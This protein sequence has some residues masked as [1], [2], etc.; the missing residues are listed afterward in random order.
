MPLGFLLWDGLDVDTVLSDVIQNLFKAARFL[1][2]RMRT[3]KI[4][5]SRAIEIQLAVETEPSVEMAAGSVIVGT[6]GVEFGGDAPVDD[7]PLRL[8]MSKKVIRVA[9]QRG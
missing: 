2:I 4:E 8:K 3:I 1:D 9:S 6:F 5:A 7:V